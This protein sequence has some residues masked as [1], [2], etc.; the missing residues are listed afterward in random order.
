MGDK[1]AT[2][3]CVMIV[4]FSRFN[5]EVSVGHYGSSKYWKSIP[6]GSE[7]WGDKKMSRKSNAQVSE[8]K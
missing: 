7:V 3:G 4:E 5:S 6:R 1:Y 8:T 2:I